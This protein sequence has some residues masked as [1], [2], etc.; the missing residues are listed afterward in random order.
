MILYPYFESRILRKMLIK[1]FLVVFFT[2]LYR[3]N[4]ARK[5]IIFYL[6][7]YKLKKIQRFYFI[8]SVLIGAFDKNLSNFATFEKELN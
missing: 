4:I 3:N 5:N 7:N 8:T 2:F 1:W 6:N